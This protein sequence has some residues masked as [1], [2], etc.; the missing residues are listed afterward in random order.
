M[1]RLQRSAMS[2]TRA[3]VYVGLAVLLVGWLA[4]AAGVAVTSRS[5]QS[6]PGPPDVSATQAMADE[7]QTQAL[8]LRQ[9]MAAAPVPRTPLRNPFAFAAS[10]GAAAP[11]PAVAGPK[12]P[13]EAALPTTPDEPPLQLIG[14]AGRE[15]AAGMVRTA[16]ITADSDELFMVVVGDTL[17]GRY[18]VQAVGP[19]G[20][21][22]MDLATKTTLRLALR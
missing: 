13:V 17:G 6:P 8:R 9:R 7:V 2:P 20:A 15:T 22:L 14:I 10:S 3:T 5:P 1:V 19:E 4:A 12:P 16:L 11:R 18:R 21:E